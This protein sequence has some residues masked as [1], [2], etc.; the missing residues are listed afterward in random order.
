MRK[1]FRNFHFK[2]NQKPQIKQQEMEKY[3][4][5]ETE[6]RWWLVA[7]KMITYSFFFLSVVISHIF[8]K[9]IK[10]VVGPSPLPLTDAILHTNA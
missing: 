8:N 6:R 10:S 1:N 7:K 4:K 5:N 3:I 9:H 2:H